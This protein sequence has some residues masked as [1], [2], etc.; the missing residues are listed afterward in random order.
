M[1][2]AVRELCGITCSSIIP[3]I[4]FPNCTLK[5]I[6]PLITKEYFKTIEVPGFWSLKVLFKMKNVFFSACFTFRQ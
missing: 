2:D 6:V 1:L 3:F 5:K 4:F